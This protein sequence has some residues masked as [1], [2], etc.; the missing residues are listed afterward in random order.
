MAQ[1]GRAKDAA[2]PRRGKDALRAFAARVAPVDPGPTALLDAAAAE[3]MAAFDGAGVD[4]LLLKGRAIVTLLYQ[5]G[6]R[7]DYGDVDVLVAPARLGVA[8]RTL[9]DLGYSIDGTPT[10]ISDVDEVVHAQPWIRTGRGPLDQTM[11][12]LHWRLPGCRAAAVDA[13]EALSARRTWIE[14]GG[15]R[16]A[17][18][19]RCGQALHLAIHATQHGPIL[20]L[21]KVLDELSLALER[22]PRDVW[23][24]AALLAEQLDATE[25]FAAGLRLLPN[26][27]ALASEL[28]LPATI[29]LDWTLMHRQERPRGAVHLYA[30]QELKG[31]AD[32]L[33]ILRRLLFPSRAW[34]AQEHRWIRSSGP[35]LIAAYAVHLARL[36][37]WAARAWRFRA[38]ARRAGRLG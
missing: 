9:A 4:A 21:D 31:V 12:D 22:W 25:A 16:T 34:L 1:P 18:L 38:R 17:A 30:L 37:L 20:G 15:R 5:P 7:R 24:C 14:V 35:L 32:R 11:V 19:D 27:A 8:E 10:G 23:R 3:V 13:W 6:E 28:Q 33:R 26:G 36:P 2:T 29:E